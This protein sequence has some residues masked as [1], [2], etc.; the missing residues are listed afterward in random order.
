MDEKQVLVRVTEI[1][2]RTG[3]AG[4][5]QFTVTCIPDDK[6][7]FVEYVALDGRSV[8]MDEYNVDGKKIYAG[9]S[10]RTQTVY[11]SSCR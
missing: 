7:S 1:F 3:V 8:Y 4:D 5:E 11:L 9:F 2:L 10:S 6:T